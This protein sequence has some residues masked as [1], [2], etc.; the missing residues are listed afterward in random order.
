MDLARPGAAKTDLPS[1]LRN[2]KGWQ[3]AHVN[4]Q[5]PS[6]LPS[7]FRFPLRTI[8]L[9]NVAYSIRPLRTDSPQQIE[10]HRRLDTGYC[11]P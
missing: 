6:W 1:Y 5:P 4:L 7:Q 3:K 11:S 2:N 9:E 8:Q 10:H